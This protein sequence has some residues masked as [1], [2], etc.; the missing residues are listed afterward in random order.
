[1]ISRRILEASI[2]PEAAG[3][4][5]RDAT[6]GDE[7][8]GVGAGVVRGAIG[9]GELAAAAGRATA[10]T[11]EGAGGMLGCGPTGFP[12]AGEAKMLLSA[13]AAAGCA[14]AGSACAAFGLRR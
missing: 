10:G 4:R 2:V 14:A 1:M 6:P 9:V 7:E 8:I 5:D 3:T 12:C 13:A 11:G